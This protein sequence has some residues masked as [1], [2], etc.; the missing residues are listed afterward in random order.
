MSI[1]ILDRL[2][3]LHQNPGQQAPQILMDT[4]LSIE[5]GQNLQ[6]QLLERWLDQGEELGGWKIGMTSGASRNAMGDGIRP[7]GFILKS[8]IG[9]DNI[10]L[11]LK[12]L[13]KGG[14]K[15]EVCFGFDS[16]LSA[17]TTI[18]DA[19]L[20]VA[21]IHPGFEIN[22]KRLPNTAS[23]GLRV[24]DNLSNWGLVY[25]QDAGT[26]IEIN[27]IF[28]ELYANGEAIE[29]TVSKD[30]IDDH[31][32]SICTLA[33]K[34]GAHG[35]AIEKEHKVITGAFGK[36]PFAKGFFKG[37]FSHELGSVSLEII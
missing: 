6:I 1:S 20:K 9:V 7:F 37:E 34:L 27:E 13:Y 11:D 23:S 24:A 29:K 2:W 35:L 26:D 32:Q 31:Y 15:N 30:H 22:Q 16:S 21:S 5:E 28:V 17:G 25:G 18:E 14:V 10:K 36:T 4:P 3:F 8:R 33:N 12:E 19:K